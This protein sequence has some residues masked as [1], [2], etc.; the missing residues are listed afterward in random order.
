MTNK[1]AQTARSPVSAIK[2]DERE[3]LRNRNIG[4]QSREYENKY[5]ILISRESSRLHH[6]M[7]IY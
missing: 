6:R 3:D 5:L 1:S 2:E 4:A 7:G